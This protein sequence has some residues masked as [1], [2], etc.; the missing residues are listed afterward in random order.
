MGVTPPICDGL[1]AAGIDV[2]DGQINAFDKLGNQP[3]YG[4]PAAPV[5]ARKHECRFFRV[6]GHAT[7]QNDKG[8][9]LGVMNI[10]A[11]LFMAGNEQRLWLVR[12]NCW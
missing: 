7:A 9:R 5:A 8:Q 3:P 12:I 6:P 1:L 11:N 4:H 2:H 10:L